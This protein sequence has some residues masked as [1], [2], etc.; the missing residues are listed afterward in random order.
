MPVLNGHPA[1]GRKSAGSRPR[2]GIVG[3]GHGKAGFSEPAE[4]FG[5]VELGLGA[6]AV[7]LG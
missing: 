4:G 5:F 2:G 6:L 1:R 3:A 7:T